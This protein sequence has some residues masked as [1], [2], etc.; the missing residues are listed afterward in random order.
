MNGD[1]YSDVIV[2]SETYDD[3]AS[4]NEGRAFVYY[5]SVTGLSA[6]PIV[7]QMMR[8]RQVPDLVIV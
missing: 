6:T 5:G 3:G 8:I 2:G 1:G 4:T 7:H